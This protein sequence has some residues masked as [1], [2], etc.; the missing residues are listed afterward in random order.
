MFNKIKNKKIYRVIPAGGLYNSFNS[1]F[2]LKSGSKFPTEPSNHDEYTYGDYRYIFLEEFNGWNVELNLSKTNRCMEK[3]EP[4]LTHVG[5]TPVVAM[6]GTF[7][8]CKRMTEAPLIPKNVQNISRVFSGC[9]SLAI[10][11]EIPNGV[12]NMEHAFFGCSSIT[13]APKIPNSVQVITMCFTGCSSLSVPSSI[14]DSVTCADFA[15]AGCPLVKRLFVPQ[16]VSNAKGMF[17]RCKMK[18]IPE[19][20]IKECMFYNTSID[21][22]EYCIFIDKNQNMKYKSVREDRTYDIPKRNI[23]LELK[24]VRKMIISKLT[25]GLISN[26]LSTIEVA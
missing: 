17:A 3:Y 14:P 18:V 22:D 5:K 23:V 2:K 19:G 7:A 16:S 8:N 6:L 15:F 20:N 4:I 11:P 25:S 13:E 12:I 21:L 9:K 26:F 1:N 10:V 24:I